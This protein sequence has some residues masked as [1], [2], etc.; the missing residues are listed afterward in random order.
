MPTSVKP[1]GVFENPGS[2]GK[3]PG[4]SVVLLQYGSHT[5]KLAGQVIELP[6]AWVRMPGIGAEAAL[7]ETRSP[8]HVP[9]TPFSQVRVP[10]EQVT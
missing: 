2:V 6:S 8:M 4:L 1:A 5:S 9:H 3:L 7:T 10:I